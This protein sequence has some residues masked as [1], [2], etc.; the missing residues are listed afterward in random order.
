MT[1]KSNVCDVRSTNYDYNSCDI[2]DIGELMY[3]HGLCDHNDTF[4]LVTKRR[5]LV[6][7]V[8]LVTLAMLLTL[9]AFVLP[10]TFVTNVT[11]PLHIVCDMYDMCKNSDIY[12]SSH[13]TY[14]GSLAGQQQIK[15]MLFICHRNSQE[16]KANTAFSIIGVIYP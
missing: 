11:D 9:T 8:K 12:D 16:E 3:A 15:L 13:C 2:C 14:L 6:T 1:N 10:V 5:K 7:Y 4:K